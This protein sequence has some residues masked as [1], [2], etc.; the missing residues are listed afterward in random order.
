[1]QKGGGKK[2]GKKKERKQKQK[3]DLNT[4]KEN[5]KIKNNSWENPAS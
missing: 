3:N 2:K 4:R 5:L 1:M